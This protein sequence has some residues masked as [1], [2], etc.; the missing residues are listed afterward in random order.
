MHFIFIFI[1]CELF[2][3]PSLW[4]RLGFHAGSG[5][6][7]HKG[8]VRNFKVQYRHDTVSLLLVE[9]KCG[10]PKKRFLA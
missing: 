9:E 4:V 1:R 8:E 10:Y 3:S 5:E 6:R 7:L 2:L